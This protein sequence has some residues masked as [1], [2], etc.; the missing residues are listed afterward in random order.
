M[1]MLSSV[2]YAPFMV[3]TLHGTI[4]YPDYLSVNSQ[5]IIL[6]TFN[7]LLTQQYK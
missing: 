4:L 2:V 5:E 1:Q 3:E 7:P 6:V